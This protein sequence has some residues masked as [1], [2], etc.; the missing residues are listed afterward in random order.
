MRRPGSALGSTPDGDRLDAL[1]LAAVDGAFT[2]AEA[3]ELAE[4]VGDPASRTR[5]LRLLQI[6][7]ALRGERRAPGVEEAAME[8]IREGRRERVVAGV[9]RAID[10]RAAPA[11]PA[12]RRVARSGL[13]LGAALV[14]ALAVVAI[15]VSRRRAAPAELTAAGA[16]A[17]V[18]APE[19][20]GR[21]PV[22]EASGT[23]AR[24]AGRVRALSP[25]LEVV[26]GESIATGGR[27]AAVLDLGSGGRIHL[28]AST[29]LTLMDPDRAQDRS[30][31]REARV[32]H[33]AAGVVRAALAPGVEAI[34]AAPSV[35]PR[36]AGDGPLALLTPHARA[37]A[38][39]ATFTVEV[40][41]ARTALAVQQGR[42]RFERHRGAAASDV[43]AGQQALAEADGQVLAASSSEDAV[44]APAVVLSFDFE[45][46]EL[47]ALLRQG[48]IV[49]G[50]C[51]PGSRYCAI[52]MLD[53]WDIGNQ[54]VA[55]SGGAAVAYFSSGL[56]LS[57][58]FWA[59]PETE[60]V[61]VQAW[62][63]DRWQNHS[64]FIDNRTPGTWTHAEVRMP[65]VRGERGRAWQ[66]GDRIE[67][68][69]LHGGRA[70]R[71]PFYVDNLRLVD[72]PQ[73]Q[74]ASP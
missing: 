19:G 36:A 38:I 66:E 9:L 55:L 69:R 60:R 2:S 31:H 64:A 26:P 67:N 25:G 33:V 35:G 27:G 34:A 59:G 37:T 61:R 53:P 54:V 52:G 49:S 65:D 24:R 71:G 15:F 21:A 32:V 45:D 50:P 28:G 42:V 30:G 17:R 8:A 39:G 13:F 51:P 16:L 62:N 23:V 18:Q 57:F 22:L 5:H 43:R 70:G 63:P 10:G 73:S 29:T 20:I 11:R 47:P 56:L 58:D 48:A 7:A 68:V 12:V 74:G 40:T 4:L 72:R 44:V 14:A 6:E 3:A 41:G 46:G 1:T